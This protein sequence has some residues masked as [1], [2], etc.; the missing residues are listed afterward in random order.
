MVVTQAC[1]FRKLLLGACPAEGHPSVPN[2]L[3]FVKRSL[4]V[5]RDDH[6]ALVLPVDVVCQVHRSVFVGPPWRPWNKSY[7][8][9]CVGFELLHHIVPFRQLC[10]HQKEKEIF[11]LQN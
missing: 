10:A 9:M 11:V 7:C 2:L 4:C 8:A 5:C 3:T 1:P 6:M